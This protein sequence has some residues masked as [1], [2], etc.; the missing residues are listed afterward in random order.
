[1]EL[2]ASKTSM[3]R[4]GAR[5]SVEEIVLLAVIAY[6]IGLRLLVTFVAPPVLDESYYWLWGRHLALSY[7]DHPPLVGWLQGL[8][9][10]LFGQSPL[11]LRWTTWV[12]LAVELWVFL[13][14]AQRV[15]G[16]AWR[17]MFLRSSAVFFAMPIYGFFAGLA[18]LDHLLIALMMAS[19][20]LFLVF[21]SEV[22]D[23]G[24][25]RSSVLF[26]AAVLLGFAALTKYSGAFVGVAVLLAVLIRPRLRL[27][28]GDWRMYAA[29]LLAIAMQAPVFVWNYQ[30][31]FESFLYQMGSRHGTTGFTGINIEGMK[32]ALGNALLMASPF[33]VPAIIRF[34]WARGGS[35]FER[36]GRTLAILLFWPC[37]LLL[38]YIANF[39]WIMVWWSITLYLLFVP[40]AGRYTRPVTLWLHLAYGVVVNTFVSV[41]YSVVP[42]LL[43]FGMAPGMETESMYGW[44]Q[45]AERVTELKAE[46]DADF[47]AMNYAQNASQLAYALNDPDVLA[48]SPMRNSFDDWSDPVAHLGKTAIFLEQEQAGTDW[49]S[50]FGR[51]TE[52]ERVPA[53]VWGHTLREY[54]VYL[55]E[56]FRGL[57]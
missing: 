36:V 50:S 20:Y 55:A 54:V 56:D 30:H 4:D 28:L 38:L 33:V 5:F 13:R 18:F 1:M 17:L 35:T 23:G 44:P 27:L 29:A 46:H 3:S 57:Q 24:R 12:A 19:G 45:I 39:S 26:G 14:V 22:E 2:A 42:V 31:G 43:L 48:I 10:A 40:F 6:F 9:Y 47:I 11:A 41:T 8:S 25:G 21:L 53:Q 16:D 49:R 32:A 51:I 52:L 34:F 7:Y 15:G 37:A